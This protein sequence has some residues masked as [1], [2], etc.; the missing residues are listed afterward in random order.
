MDEK[1]HH[2]SFL[3]SFAKCFGTFIS[4]QKSSSCNIYQ[5]FSDFTNSFYFQLVIMTFMEEMLYQKKIF[6][7][8]SHWK[9]TI[10]SYLELN[11]NASHPTSNL[12]N[13]NRKT[14]LSSYY[15]FRRIKFRESFF[16]IFLELTSQSR[17]E[18]I[19]DVYDH[20]PI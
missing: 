11:Q 5:I 7:R 2:K 4:G 18:I 6:P 20:K 16:Q 12:P 3:G 14:I 15:S 19:F 17:E 13:N 1:F 10:F 9:I 8:I